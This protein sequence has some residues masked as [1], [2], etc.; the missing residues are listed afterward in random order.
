MQLGSVSARLQFLYS[1]AAFL[2]PTHPKRSARIAGGAMPF[3]CLK[4]DLPLWLNCQQHEAKTPPNFPAHLTPGLMLMHEGYGPIPGLKKYQSRESSRLFL[5]PASGS[6]GP[7]RLMI[8]A[9]FTDTSCF[10]GEHP[11]FTQLQPGV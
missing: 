4:K 9:D 6:S 10:G 1:V 11:C 2:R 7:P 5:R 3:R 8:K